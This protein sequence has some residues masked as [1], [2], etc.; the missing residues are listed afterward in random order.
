MTGPSSARQ[1]RRR[2]RF[3]HMETDMKIMRCMA[4]AAAGIAALSTLAWG[5]GLWST[6]PIIGQGS[7]CGSTVSGT[8]AL[9]GITGQGQGTL[10]SI[11]GQTIPA[12]PSGLTGQETIP[13]D[14]YGLN[15]TASQGGAPAQTARVPVGLI[16]PT[17]IYQGS[18]AAPK[19]LLRNGD[20][21]VNPFQSGTAQASNIS[22]TITTSADGF[23]M[24]GGAASAI[25]WSQ[26]TGATDIV[27]NQFTASLRFQ[28]A[29][30]NAN[31]AAVCQINVLTSQDSVALQGQAFVYSFWAKAGGNFSPTS[32]NI[33]VTVASGTGSDQSAANLNAGTWTGQANAITAAGTSNSSFPV[34][35][36][37]NQATLQTLPSG[38]TATWVQYW[39]SGT[40][41]ATAT[42][43]GT[44]ICWTPVGTA[45]AND[46]V[47]TSNHQ[48]E[49]VGAG[50]ITPTAFEHHNAQQDLA[51]AQRFLWVLPE[52]NTMLYPCAVTGVNAVSCMLPTP[53]TMRAAPTV[54]IA[55]GGFQL[56]IDGA[57]GA[58]VAGQAGGTS[59]KTVAVIT[60][61]NTVTAAVHSVT[62]RGSGTTGSITSTSEL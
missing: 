51:L 48:L 33:V 16:A 8:G 53:V 17:S 58:A 60:T 12:G 59:S 61:T 57:A 29:S 21:S 50:V 9:G 3:F 2:R 24:L 52:T 15:P 40:I 44:Q 25:Q 49:I 20:I 34:S 5:A 41:P 1:Q 27:A 56:V 45:G 47:E 26:Q 4:L 36:T 37:S 31:T 28:R 42:Q 35:V 11:C 62:L 46:W 19:N 30:A 10:G 18:Y 23:R 14:L 38:A 22:N 13:V 54:S 39:V 6:L 7:F 43:V 55:A 32:G